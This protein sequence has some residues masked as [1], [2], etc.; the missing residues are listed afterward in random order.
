MGSFNYQYRSNEP[1]HNRQNENT[2]NDKNKAVI[3]QV[4]TLRKQEKYEF[5]AK[6][7]I[8]KSSAANV[9]IKGNEPLEVSTGSRVEL[10]I[11]GQKVEQAKVTRV[12]VAHISD[13]VFNSFSNASRII[14]GAGLQEFT[15][16]RIDKAAISETV[17]IE[18]LG[19][20]IPPS[21]SL[22]IERK[23]GNGK[24]PIKKPSSTDNTS[25]NGGR[26]KR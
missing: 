22:A 16:N 23:P 20:C 19:P 26:K 2:N 6:N 14:S 9:Q 10:T 3:L 11:D 5:V 21:A 15:K 8:V 13:T 24:P 25:G 17:K 4:E 18:R 12:E 1:E 7:G